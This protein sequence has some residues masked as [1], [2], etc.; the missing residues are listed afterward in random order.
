MKKKRVALGASL[1]ILIVLCVFLVQ[2]FIT[3][4]GGNSG[5]NINQTQEDTVIENDITKINTTQKLAGLEFSNIE[6]QMDENNLCVLTADVLNTTNEMKDA[7][8]IR[9]KVSNK[10]GEI[11]DVF[12]G[13]IPSISAKG[14]ASLSAAIRKDVTKATNVTF[15]IIK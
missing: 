13:S 1:I 5:G 3:N 7:H 8:T 4:K 10:T 14:K 6:I 9:V 2:H 12:A 11:N 15:E